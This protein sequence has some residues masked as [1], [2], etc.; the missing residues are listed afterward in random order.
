MTDTDAIVL[1][2]TFAQKRVKVVQLLFFGL[3]GILLGYLGSFFVQSS[4][5]FLNVS[6]V[7]GAG[8]E[9]FVLH[10]GLWKYTPIDSAYQGYSYCTEYDDEYTSDV[11]LIPRVAGICCMVSGAYALIVLWTYLIFGK[12]TYKLWNW[13]IIMATLACLGQAL[14]FSFITGSLCKR[15]QCS[16]GPGGYLSLFSSLG[17]FILAFEMYYNKP[18]S[19]MMSHISPG[20]PG[21]S[22]MTTLEM[23][24]FSKG[25]RAY[26]QRLSST[27][28]ES[29]PTLNELQRKRDGTSS[30]GRGMMDLNSIKRSGSYKPPIFA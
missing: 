8:A 21:A 26:V 27:R 11:P 1:H 13:A 23:K 3:I 18:M 16:L 25:A 15:Y 24:D 20:G 9:V 2:A 6:V 22:V 7:V 14:T 10:Y 19:M 17:W 29:L 30:F 4:C 12:A 28:E 5:H